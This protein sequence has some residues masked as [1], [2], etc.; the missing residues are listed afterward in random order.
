[1]IRRRQ[2]LFGFACTLGSAAPVRA[3]RVA[4]IHLGRLGAAR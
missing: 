2:L 1:M 4:Y 3:Y